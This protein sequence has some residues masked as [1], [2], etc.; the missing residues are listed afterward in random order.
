MVQI[1]PIRTSHCN[2]INFIP[3]SNSPKA[4]SQSLCRRAQSTNQGL[5]PFPAAIIGLAFR[6]C[7][8]ERRTARQ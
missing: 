8:V 1:L 2:R 4:I 3:V 5:V 7:G 6:V